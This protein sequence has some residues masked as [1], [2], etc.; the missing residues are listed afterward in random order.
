MILYKRHGKHSGFSNQLYMIGLKT[1]IQIIKMVPV[2]WGN[3]EQEELDVVGTQHI[4]GQ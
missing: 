1:L 4:T 2:A 3:T